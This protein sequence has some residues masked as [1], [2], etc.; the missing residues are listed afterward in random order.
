MTTFY[1][2]RHGET[3]NNRLGKLSGWIDTPLT[4][5]GTRDIKLT[6]AKLKGVRFDSIHASDLGRAF[7]T[8][9]LIARNIGFTDE[10]HRQSGLREVSYGDYGNL[11][12]DD[13]T[14]KDSDMLNDTDFQPPNGETLGHMQQRVLKCLDD[15]AGEK[16]DQTILIVTHD[17]PINAVYAS[18]KHIDLGELN[19]KRVNPHDFVAKFTIEGGKVASFDEV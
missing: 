6:V 10:I 13:V 9:Y 19:G 14:A 1:I 12:W 17:G 7:T 4:V 5:E 3:E 11:L 2:C 16:P 18:F 8:A 15:I